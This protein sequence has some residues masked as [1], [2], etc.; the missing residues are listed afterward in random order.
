MSDA[1]EQEISDEEYFG[2][3]Q[4][5]KSEWD[6]RQVDWLL[7][8]LCGFINETNLNFGITLTVGGN[9]ITGTLISHQTYFERLANDLST[10]FA[11]ASPETQE[12]IHARILGFHA[13]VDPEKTQLPVQFIH[14]DNA[15]VHTGGH[16]ILP[17]K[18]TLWRGKIAAVEGFILGELN[19][20][21]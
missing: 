11:F 13:P 2:S 20:A 16:Q 14:L 21:N 18:G 5:V 17:D 6:G 15:R 7:Q 4:T 12:A 3:T 19:S 10:P 1:T 9:M 8:W